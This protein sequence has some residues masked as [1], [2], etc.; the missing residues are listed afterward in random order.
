MGIFCGATTRLD[1][2]LFNDKIRRYLGD[3]I[4]IDYYRAFIQEDQKYLGIAVIP[5]RGPVLERFVS[6]A[7][8]ISERRL[9]H[10][11]DSAIREGDCSQ[12]LTREEADRVASEIHVPRIGQL[13]S[14]DEPMYRIW[15]PDYQQFVEREKYCTLT[16]KTLNSERTSVTS[17]IGIGVVG[18]TALATWAVMR[19]FHKRDLEYIVSI[20]AKDRE[21]TTSGIVGIQPHITS[22]ES[23]L[24]SICDVLGFPDIKMWDIKRKERE[25]RDMLGL[26]KGLLFVDNLETVDDARI[27][28]FLD[29]LPVGTRAIVTSRRTRVRVSVF[30]VE[31]PPLDDSENV[32]FIG[33]LA[34]QPNFSHVRELSKAEEIRV[35]RACDSIPL[36]IRWV[37][38][39]SRSASEA[40]AMADG[41]SQSGRHGEELLEFS[42]RRV[43]DEMTEAEKSVVHILSLFQSPVPTEALL[44]GSRQSNDRTL[45]AIDDLVND[46]VIQRFFDADRNDYTYGLL[47]IARAFVYNEV[48]QL[49]DLERRIRSCLERWFEARDIRDPQEQLVV[50]E[51]R[52]GKGAA[53]SSLLDLAMSAQRRGDISTAEQLFTQ[54]LQRNPKSWRAARHYA[55]FQRHV[56]GNTTAALELYAQAAAHAPRRGEERGLIYREWGMLLRNSGLPDATDQAIEKFEVARV[57]MPNDPVTLHALATMYNRKGAYY[58]VIELMEP[59]EAHPQQKTVE[60]AVS[61]LAKAYERQEDI[62]KLAKL[63]DRHKGILVRE[64]THVG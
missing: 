54:A 3:K 52:Q 44:V 20:T 40:L 33:A 47:P 11:G 32:R 5:G 26:A 57:D 28:D 64:N 51:I 23:L 36:A 39:R 31:L 17:I 27:I 58:R 13:Y 29:D 6:D 60:M 49:P 8:I 46:S 24:D 14:V 2:K 12:I 62:A 43:F 37:L 45:D 35:A 16:E 22:F 21:L 38:A 10:Q 50:R 63:K 56:L 15:S 19:A 9:F 4:W 55:E 48:S 59:L 53:E 18:K 61:L 7:P 42:F 41:L 25:V 34:S 30:P 1:S